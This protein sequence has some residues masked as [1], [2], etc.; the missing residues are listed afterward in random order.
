MTSILEASDFSF[1]YRGVRVVSGDKL[2]ME[3]GQV[4]GIAGPNG[5]GKSTLF[6]GLLGLLPPLSG[7][8]TRRTQ[9]IGYVPQKEVLDELYPLS[10]AE[11]VQMGAFGTLSG[12]RRLGRDAKDLAQACLQRVDLPDVGKQAYS[13]LSGGQRQRVLLA[14]ALMVKPK[15]MMLDEPTS[16]VDALA[17]GV[18]MELI[19]RLAKDEDLAVAIVSHRL[20]D[21]RH[22]ATVGVWVSN[23]RAQ[24]GPAEELL[25]ADRLA[26][27][28]TSSRGDK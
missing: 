26:F 11:V 28:P 6:R 22:A 13:S 3:A 24:V 21:L 4:L 12:F 16:G 18:I 5:A 20:H 1:G 2:T 15:L 7:Q 9:A 19:L 23:G 8:V 27:A 25:Q 10:A 14:R 17:A